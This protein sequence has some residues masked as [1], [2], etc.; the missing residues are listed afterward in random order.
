MFLHNGYN[1]R[2]PK[3]LDPSQYRMP[4]QPV[5]IVFCTNP[6][7]PVLNARDIPSRVREAVEFNA[8][9]NGLELIAWSIMPDHLHVAAQVGSD[10][11]DLLKFIHAFKKRTGRTI[12]EAGVAG[13]I[14]QRSFWD[15]HLRP[16]ETLAQ[17]VQ[18]IA[19]NPVDGG[20][21]DHWNQWRYTWLNDDPKRYGLE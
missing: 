7:R 20:L 11:G 9:N 16:K 4:L 15:R 8:E 2:H 19:W 5:G 18:H 6:D 3:R 13:P 12:H 21:C 14:W 17:L 1:R 10:G